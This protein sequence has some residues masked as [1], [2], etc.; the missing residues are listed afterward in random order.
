MRRALLSLSCLLALSACRHLCPQPDDPDFNPSRDIPA[1]S[2]VRVTLQDKNDPS[3]MSTYVVDARR[4]EV[5]RRLDG[6]QAVEKQQTRGTVSQQQVAQEPAADTD[7]TEMAVKVYCIVTSSTP[8]N[9]CPD[10]SAIDPKMEQTGGDDPKH[11][12]K[13]YRTRTQDFVVRIARSYFEAV[14]KSGIDQPMQNLQG[15]KP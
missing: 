13:Q 10:A 11:E 1:D 14:K 9:A 4:G 5:V 12:I 8:E 6:P 7:A 3:R 15:G 2:I